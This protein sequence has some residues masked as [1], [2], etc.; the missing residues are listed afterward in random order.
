MTRTPLFLILGLVVAAC[1]A[2]ERRL[3]SPQ[4]AVEERVASR[5]SSVEVLEVSLPTSAAGEE[6]MVEDE[7]G[8]LVLTDLLWA[9][10]P[11][12]ALTLALTR[13]LMQITGARVAPE[14][15]PFDGFAAARVDVRV[16]RF[17]ADESG[18]VTM[19]GQYF[20]AD[21]DGRGRDRARLF[22]LAV[23][24]ANLGVAEAAQARAQLVADLALLIA[25]DG[26]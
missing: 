17:V 14:P 23:P 10:D 15:W 21:L 8:A 13:N 25:R 4:I 9:D 20:V 3:A 1:G 26:L 5:F 24:A 12:R 22:S 6:I 2:E 11:A 19:A 16:E 18:V 7:T